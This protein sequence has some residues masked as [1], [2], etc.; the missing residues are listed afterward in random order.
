MHRG[1]GKDIKK[2]DFVIFGSKMIYFI[3]CNFYGSGGSKLNEVARAYQELASKFIAYEDKRFIWITDG[4]G[5]L[6]AKNKLEEAYKSVCIYNLSQLERL[7]NE[8]K[9]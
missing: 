4:Q 8:L 5:W 6:N 9:T 1:F 7:L 2:F 3:E